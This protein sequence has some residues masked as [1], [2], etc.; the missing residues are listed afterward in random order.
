MSDIHT[1]GPSTIERCV[2]AWQ[3]TQA[4]IAADAEPEGDEQAIAA[5]ANA[6]PRILS[7]GELLRRIIRG[8]VLCELREEEAKIVAAFNRGVQRRYQRR[9]EWLRFELFEV[10][11]ALERKSEATP[12]GTASIKAGLP[13]LVLTDEQALPDKY[14]KIVRVPDKLAIA[15]DLK[16]GKLIPGAVM[17]NAMPVLALRKPRMIEEQ[18][19]ETNDGGPESRTDTD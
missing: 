9:A 5:A 13:S 3:R 15:A 17:S 6:D 2:A 14:V 12:Y 18:E 4:A 8:L 16:A 1:P 7:P 19:E 10:L 11:Q